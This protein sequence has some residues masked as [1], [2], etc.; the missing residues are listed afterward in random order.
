VS[1]VGFDTYQQG[2]LC[3]VF[4]DNPFFS[5]Y[6]VLQLRSSYT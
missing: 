1:K 4:A 3:T 2:G 5:D 6:N